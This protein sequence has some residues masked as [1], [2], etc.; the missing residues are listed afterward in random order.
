MFSFGQATQFS[1]FYSSPTIL[2]P[3]YTGL[4]NGSRLSLNYREQWPSIPGQFTTYALAFDHN[5]TRIHS[6]F[7]LQAFRD[8]AGPGKLGL[9][10]VGLL[11][12]YD[13]PI[14]KFWHV[15]PGI[16]LMFS[17]RSLHQRDLIMGDQI[18]L[19]GDNASI[20]IEPDHDEYASYMDATASLIAYSHKYWGGFTFDH[21]LR[22]N[23][24][25]AGVISKVPI[26]MSIFGGIKFDLAP[27]ARDYQESVV[28]AF[29][30]KNSLGMQSDQFDI[31]IYWTK[32]P[33]VIGAWYRGLPI[34]QKRMGYS[35]ENIDA[36][37]LLVGYRMQNLQIG[38]SY[39]FTISDLMNHTGGSHEIS[40]VYEFNQSLRFGR[41]NKYG[42]VPCPNF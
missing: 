21:M 22:P 25:L 7:G 42:V 15:R 39:D 18:N 2:A 11:Y 8:V 1:Q 3:S 40:I 16:N 23:E 26:R 32:T 14:N 35:M 34:T 13:I 20:S 28:I 9:T 37:V 29:N 17:Q 24:S 41:N 19:T 30:Y 38:Y 31:G 36:L 5:F 33:I 27:R 12:A 10:N 4:T 6:G